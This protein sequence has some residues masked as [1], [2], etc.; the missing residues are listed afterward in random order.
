MRKSGQS[1]HP[2][3]P[4]RRQL[5]SRAAIRRPKSN[6]AYW[7]FGIH[8]VSAALLNP[9]RRKHRLVVSKNCFRKLRAEIK[10][11]GL[12]PEFAEGR[13]L[14]AVMGQD[15]VH[16]GVALK[17][18]PLEVVSIS[19]L[20]SMAGA[21]ARVLL[22][23]RVSDPHNVGAILRSA[24]AFGAMAVVTT[25]RHAPPETGVLAK[26]ASGALERVP[27]VRIPNLSAALK[28]LKEAE[29]NLI[30]LDSEAEEELAMVGERFRQGRIALVL[31]SE[32]RGLRPSTQAV[33]D[34]LASI[35]CNPSLGSL[36]VSN[37]AAIALYE[38]RMRQTDHGRSC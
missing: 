23:D 33:C 19:S 35:A 31:G 26:T 28:L 29:F 38:T 5:R 13:K 3:H 4:K 1:R 32:G 7:M 34:G 36:N 25:R 20:Q 15:S 22:L 16:Q 30:G 37:A 12:R 2:A 11:S 14:T 10:S 18:S 27:Y 9:A 8:A 17:V 24:D 21:R 6:H